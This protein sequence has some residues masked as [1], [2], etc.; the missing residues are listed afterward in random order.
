[1]NSY[2]SD[3]EQQQ[4]KENA[5]SSPSEKLIRAAQNGSL[6][7][8]MAA[9]EAGADVN[10]RGEGDETALFIAC[11]Q[12]H[13][14]IARYLLGCPG[15][16]ITKGRL[17]LWPQGT[18]G[19]VYPLVREQHNHTPLYT[20]IAE[21]NLS[22]ARMLLTHPDSSRYLQPDEAWVGVIKGAFKF[23][24]NSEALE[25]LL[26]AAAPDPELL[27][28]TISTAIEEA[29]S[30]REAALPLAGLLQRRKGIDPS[31]ILRALAGHI[32][33]LV[34]HDDEH[35][36]AYTLEHAGSLCDI[37]PLLSVLQDL[38]QLAR[39]KKHRECE[40]L[41]METIAQQGGAGD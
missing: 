25:A 6:K 1:M 40:Q 41:L 8:V 35:S 32:R 34:N 37:H 27:Q 4:E 9:V 16:D 11:Q 29:F 24:F 2:M 10:A 12:N 22:I 5:A 20:A 15:I 33:S 17:S 3:S 36:L 31:L 30:W 28:L 7:G 21:N 23:M 14:R 18:A 19:L 26:E 38:L 39:Q 13:P